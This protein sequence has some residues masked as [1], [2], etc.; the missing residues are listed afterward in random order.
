[1][2]VWNISSSIRAFLVSHFISFIS[3]KENEIE[4]EMNE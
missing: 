4:T 1:M 3:Q 2:L